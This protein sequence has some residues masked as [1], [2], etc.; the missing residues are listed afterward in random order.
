MRLLIEC[1][2]VFEHPWIHSGIQRVVRN[3]IA[4]LPQEPGVECI[5]VILK[6]GAVRR[7]RKFPTA[8]EQQRGMLSRLQ[9]LCSRINRIPGRL[10]DRAKRQ[11]TARSP[12][13]ATGTAHLQ[14]FLQ[15]F[16]S[17]PLRLLTAFTTRFVD[18]RHSEPLQANAGDVLVLLDSSW[19]AENFPVIAQCK[20]QGMQIVVVVYDVV[21]ITHPHFFSDRAARVFE[22]WFAWMALEADGFMCISKSARDEVIR[23]AARYAPH[24]NP[25]F[26]YFYLGADLDKSDAT[27]KVRPS[28][29]RMYTERPVYLMVSTIEPRKNHAY[30]LDAFDILWA[31]GIDASLCIIGRIGWKCE[32]VLER[33]ANHPEHG[34]RLLVYHDADDSELEY[35]YRHAHS[36]VFSSFTEGFGLPLVEAMERGLPVMASNI[37]VFREICD[38]FAAYFDLDDPDSLAKLVA[39]HL[40]SGVVLAPNPV[41]G[42]SWPCWSELTEQFVRRI[43]NASRNRPTIRS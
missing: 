14:K 7:V 17:I 9:G 5:P 24:A 31:R 38:G 32:H 22:E 23:E 19:D 41:Q 21:S 15:F 18:S 40:Q 37:P 10:F 28:L 16:A 6:G 33:I 39:T 30:L 25:W 12:A 35:C 36:L 8:S 20:H 4:N 11:L 2:F 29:Q 1:T 43:V 26:S 13:V 34:R 42:W 3:V 27:G